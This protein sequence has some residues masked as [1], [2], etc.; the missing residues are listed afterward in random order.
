M[1]IPFIALVPSLHF[2]LMTHSEFQPKRQT[3]HTAIFLFGVSKAGPFLKDDALRPFVTGST[4][5]LPDRPQEN[6]A[7]HATDYFPKRYF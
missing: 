7:L 4:Y 5:N 3:G 6:L 1:F 2:K